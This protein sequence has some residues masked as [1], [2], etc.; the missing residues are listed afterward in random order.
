MK[1]AP[2]LLTGTLAFLLAVQPLAGGKADA[3]STGANASDRIVTV[4]PINP[5]TLQVTFEAPIPPAEVTVDTAKANFQFTGGLTLRNIPQLKTGSAA[6]YIVPT[7]VQSPGTLYSLSYKGQEPVKFTGNPYKLKLRSAAQ[8]AY[9]T[10][11]LESS[12]EDGVTDY[13]NIV[14]AY[15]GKRG[16]LEF[17]LDANLQHQGKTYQVIPSLRDSYV[18]VTPQGGAPLKAVYVPFTQNTDGRQAP[19]YRLPEGTVFEAGTSYTVTS[20][21]AEITSPTFTAKTAAALEA[22]EIRAVNATTLQVTLASDPKDELFASRRLLLSAPD[23]TLL[24]AQ[25]KVTTRQGATA[26]FEILNGGAMVPGTTYAVHTVGYWL[27]LKGTQTV[28]YTAGG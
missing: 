19:K 2:S 28:T 1:L 11:E 24:T 20:D 23:G 26:T 9:D 12:L 8:V 13:S 18:I 7:T 3:R 17:A 6:T 25:Y 14:Q 15:A 4:E 5:I 22:V 10:L 21:W 27:Q 16:G